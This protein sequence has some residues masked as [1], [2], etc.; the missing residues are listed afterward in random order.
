MSRSEAR[1]LLSRLDEF[2]EVVLDFTGVTRIGQGFADEIFRVFP[3]REPTISIETENVAPEIAPMI[4][5]QN[6]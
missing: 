2:E 6:S 4:E 5:H 1:R 3:L